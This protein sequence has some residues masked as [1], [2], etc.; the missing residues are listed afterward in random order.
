MP[1]PSCSR[2]TCLRSN[3][4]WRPTI[5]FN[6]ATCFDFRFATRVPRRGRSMFAKYPAT[7]ANW[8]ESAQKSENS[9]WHRWNDAIFAPAGGD[10]SRKFSFCRIGR[11]VGWKK[12][13]QK[14][15]H[16]SGGLL[17]WYG[18]E[19]SENFCARGRA[20]EVFRLSAL[21]FERVF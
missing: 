10:Y 5:E 11:G 20:R 16:K 6:M 1:S 12:C 7:A 15:A 19:K 18:R 3:P 8:L 17:G 21:S 13:L 4:T 2:G 14:H 9:G